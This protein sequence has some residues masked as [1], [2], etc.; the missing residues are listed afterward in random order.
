MQ[1]L[2]SGSWYG[3]DVEKMKGLNDIFRCRVGNYR[4][5]FSFKNGAFDL[6]EVKRR[7]ESTYKNY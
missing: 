1:A 2:M 5:I 3:L 4:I 6:Q 7:N